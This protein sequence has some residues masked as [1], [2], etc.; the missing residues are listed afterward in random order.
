M[1]YTKTN[2]QIKKELIQTSD[3]NNEVYIHYQKGANEAFEQQELSGHK[4]CYLD[5][6]YDFSL[7]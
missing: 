6:D 5:P 1:K 3:H 4:Q 7:R 2:S